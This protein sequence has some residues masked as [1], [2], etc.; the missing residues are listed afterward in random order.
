MLGLREY[1]CLGI[2]VGR[3]TTAHTFRAERTVSNVTIVG[4]L[5][6]HHEE[7]H[8]VFKK[9]HRTAPSIA[10]STRSDMM[11][12]PRV[13]GFVCLWLVTLALTASSLIAQDF[14]ARVVGVAD[15]DT[16][17]VLRDGRLDPELT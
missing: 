4:A 14:T 17:S 3:N 16:I 7:G 2:R 9:K 15:G 1:A 6:S 10:G 13:F 12:L 8:S 11:S 5:P